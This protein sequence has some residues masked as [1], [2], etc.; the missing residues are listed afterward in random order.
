MVLFDTNLDARVVRQWRR[1]CGVV[2][3]NLDARVFRQWHRVCGVVDT[4]LDAITLPVIAASVGG[5]TLSELTV[6][7]SQLSPVDGSNSGGQVFRHNAAGNCFM[8]W[9]YNAGSPNQWKSNLLGLL[10]LPKP[11]NLLPR[12]SLLFLLFLGI[13]ADPP[14]TKEPFTKGLLAFS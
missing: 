14:Q 5:I 1:A 6:C 8:C 7:F 9:R 13:S 4:N 2:D 12:G 11:R 3:T 10:I